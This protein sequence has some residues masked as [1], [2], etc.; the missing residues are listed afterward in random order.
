[1]TEPLLIS[2]QR[3]LLRDLY[4][5]LAERAQREPQV[6]QDFQAGNAA[7]EKEFQE[8]THRVITRFESEKDSSQREFQ[9]T[10]ARV[11]KRFEAERA[12]QD[13]E[14][15]EA[16][17]RIN[18]RSETDLRAA[19]QSLQEARQTSTATFEAAKTKA[20]QEMDEAEEQINQVIDR[21]NKVRRQTTGLL[22][23]W[24]QER[25][26]GPLPESETPVRKYKDAFRHLIEHVEAAEA[27]FGELDELSLPRLFKGQRV[28]WLSVVLVVLGGGL[29]ALMGRDEWLLYLVYGLVGVAVVWGT[30]LAWLWY[31]AK[32]LVARKYLPL[33]RALADTEK[34]CDQSRQQAQAQHDSAVATAQRRQERESRQAGE[35]FKERWNTIRAR[36]EA[37]WKA[38]LL[39]YR[40]DKEASTQR[41]DTDLREAHEKYQKLRAE[42]Y[43][44]YETDSQEIHKRHYEHVT[45]TKTRYEQEW[46]ALAT[47]WREGLARVH[48][49]VEAINHDTRN[50]FPPWDSPAWT[51]W[52]PPATV[53]PVLSFGEYQVDMA[54][55]P[56]G[57]STDERLKPTVPTQFTLPALV[58]FPT[59]SCLLLKASEEGRGPGVQALQAMMLRYLTTLPPGKVRFTI[60]DPVGLG[61]NFAAFMHLADYD[62]ALVNSRIWTEAPHIEQ[63]LADLTQH[64]ENVIQKY[65]RNQ[66][67]TIEEYNAEAGEVAEPFRI[68]VIANFP[69]HFSAEAARRLVSM[70][71]SGARCGVF[72]LTT[73]DTTQEMPLG[74]SLETLEQHTV[75]LEWKEGR[76]VW[77][78]PDFG[79]FPL[80]LEVPP[81][82]DF[83]TRLLHLIGAKAREAKRVEV[84]FEFIAPPAERWWTRDTRG[85]IDVPL[86]RAGATKR[87]NLQLGKGTSQHA[88]IAGKT[89]SGKSTLLHALITN[90]AL[91]YS[92]EEV[93]LYLI[94]FKKGVEFKTYAAHH[95][96]H[97]R[98]VAIESDR[99]FGLSIL[100]RL[101]AELKIRG[102]KFREAGAQ[103]VKAF[104]EAR[105]DVVMP[106]ILLVVDEFQEFF[107]EDDKVAQDATLLLD[108]LVRQ[109]RAFGLHLL[110]GSQTLGGAYSLARS[111]IDQMA[112]RI[113][114][115]CS[116]ADGHLI[117]SDDNSAAR[118]LSRPGEAI[119]NDANGLVEGN[120]PFQVV[121]LAESRRETYLDKIHELD[122]KRH[123]AIN[124]VQ[125]VFEGNAPADIDR[126]LAL[127]E[128]VRSP[129]WPAPCAAANAWLGEAMAIKDPT[130]AVF[131]RQSGNNLLVVGQQDQ[132]ALALASNALLSLA[133]QHAPAEDLSRGAG[134]RF[135]VLDGT[136]AGTPHAGY[137][138]RLGDLLPHPVKVVGWREL[139]AVLT[140]IA[141]E[142]DRRQKANEPEGPTL[143]LFVHGLQRFKDLRRDES[144]FGFSS[145]DETASPA[146]H[147]AA[148][149]RDGPGQ[150]I[151]TLVWCDSFNN[152]TR[153]M[154]RQVLREFELR[155][156]F[157][158]SAN[159]SS[160]LIDS[161]AAGR[162]GAHRAFYH[163]EE[164]GILEK[165][166][167]Y[168][169]PT[170]SWL[171]S[172]KEHVDRKR[173]AEPA[174]QSV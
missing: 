91:V 142:M 2:R 109:G 14:R 158:M 92:P 87:Q 102:E 145:S 93:E 30:V 97:A 166:R 100:Q 160:N 84:P 75:T 135:Y 23:E 124:R 150:G 35:R 37:D 81:A 111:T 125:L 157:Q 120:N 140:E 28:I 89:G 31:S 58:A 170:E 46:A 55:L 147:F 161:P 66:Y 19:R 36:R 85:G 139:P 5:V 78:D 86:G 168:G 80:R 153:A 136:P 103:D 128:L 56:G 169:L 144:D 69:V 33:A 72:P 45:A 137:L 77:N 164:E 16:K 138:A 96:P 131:R 83:C 130:A 62:E 148:I 32:S 43:Q 13:K 49:E 155:V 115:Q 162:L 122:E 53:P 67:E 38:A 123:P 108:R 94:D 129:T 10:E 12:A 1:M 51:N 126:N 143:Y 6:N 39:K 50:L 119:Y 20:A 21:C 41:R 90:L 95:L 48:A 152:V 165:F 141:E 22:K 52:V 8:S 4:A 146:K 60:L 159:D 134:A 18:T 74:F 63:R 29:G 3:T 40:Q 156:L 113:A 9:E 76:F 118:L 47:S 172:Y 24:R 173:A 106:R 167:P 42:I 79:Q 151:H 26:F 110:L 73:A 105:P 127:G 57:H 121:W 117:L 116:E 71:S 101:D 61:E 149:A 107:S 174:R 98:V 154:D 132:M 70:V 82:E 7:A 163:S 11:T 59:R 68:P 15:D 104:R 65:L 64:M 88:L 99:E 133:V 171:A 112:V 34:A 27:S 17:K 44:R 114:L 54:T 25:D